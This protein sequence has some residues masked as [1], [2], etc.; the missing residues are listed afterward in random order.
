M[1]EEN[2]NMN[3]FETEENEVKTEETKLEKVQNKEVSFFKKILSNIIDQLIVLAMSG[4]ILLIFKFILKLIGY[5]VIMPLGFLLIFY[6]IINVLYSS[7][8]ENTKGKRSIGKKVF[9]IG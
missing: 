9:N 1:N 6:Y 3:E 4:I 8:T 2:N 5:N 7:I